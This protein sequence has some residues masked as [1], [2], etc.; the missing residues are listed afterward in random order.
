[1]L[2]NYLELNRLPGKQ[3]INMFRHMEVYAGL[4]DDPMFADFASITATDTGR[5]DGPF[6]DGDVLGEETRDRWQEFLTERDG[7][8]VTSYDTS[9]AASRQ[10]IIPGTPNAKPFRSLGFRTGSPDDNGL[11]HTLLRR[12]LADRDDGQPGTNRTWL[13]IGDETVTHQGAAST[14]TR[15]QLLS[16]IIGNSTTTSNTFIV[17]A[18]AGYFEAAQDANGLIQIGGRIDLDNPADNGD[19]DVDTGEDH[20]LGWLKH[21]VFVIDRTEFLNAYDAGTGSFDWRRLVKSRIDI[22]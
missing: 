17:Y 4:I 7:D 20:D 10:Y 14:M 3:N 2:G 5:L 15:H 19:S 1:M 21:S 11:E 12:L 16:K 6:L 13:E 9:T 18:S 8:S 22:E